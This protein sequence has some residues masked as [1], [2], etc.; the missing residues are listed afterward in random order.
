MLVESDGST[1]RGT[2]D[3]YGRL[4][5]RSGRELELGD[6]A[7]PPCLHHQACHDLLKPGYNGPSPTAR[8]QGFFVGEYDP[9]LPHSREDIIALAKVAQEQAEAAKEARRKAMADYV[10]E[11]TAKGEPIPD[12]VRT[13][14]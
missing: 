6:A 7:E 1:V 4:V 3:G 10:A 2:Y 8:D 13:S 5:T 11:L 14:S 9:K 12:W